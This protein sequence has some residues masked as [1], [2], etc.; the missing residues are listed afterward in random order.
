MSASITE[1]CCVTAGWFAAV[2]G[3]PRAVWR[4]WDSLRSLDWTRLE[5]RVSRDAC[6]QC[7]APRASSA[8]R[9]N[10]STDIGTAAPSR[11]PT[12]DGSEASSSAC[13]VG[14]S[15]GTPRPCPHLDWVEN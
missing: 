8:W 2:A 14:R 7:V 15:W 3:L 9:G 1:G 5:C 13:S 4:R 6:A 10:Y 11:T 12:S